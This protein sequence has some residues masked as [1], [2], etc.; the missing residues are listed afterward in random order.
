MME[1]AGRKQGEV[2]LAVA[3]QDH[4]SRQKG[5]LEFK[6]GQILA[7]ADPPQPKSLPPRIAFEE[8]LV[9]APLGGGG[10]ELIFRH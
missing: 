8:A 9:R 6:K 7:G 2:Y 5:F 10:Q 3:L 4:Y 1:A